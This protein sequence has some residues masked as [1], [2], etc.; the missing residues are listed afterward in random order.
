[1]RGRGSF[2]LIEVVVA[3]GILTLSL[4][5]LLQ[6]LTASQSRLARVYE[7]WRETHILMQAAEYYLLQPGEDPGGVPYTYF[8]YSDYEALCYYR[9]AENLP[10][11]YINI[12]DQLPLRT[13]V[14]ELIRLRDRKTVGTIL[15]D[16]ISYETTLAGE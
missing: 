8:P 2:T 15:V 4:A 1:M 3:L 14:V 6:I 11:D 9:D 10:E 5:G 16:K 13:C 7:K 12:P